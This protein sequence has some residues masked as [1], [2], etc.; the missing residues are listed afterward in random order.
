[1]TATSSFVVPAVGSTV[2][3]TVSDAS[4][5]IPGQMVNVAGAAGTGVAGAFQVQGV[6]GNQLTL[7]NPTPAPAIPPADATQAG[8][9]KQLSGNTTDFVD[10]T[11]TCQNLATAVT[12]TITSVRLR[13]FNAVGNC[14]FEVDQRNAQVALTTPASQTFMQDRW[15][16][17]NSVASMSTALTAGTI[18]LPGTNFAV[19]ARYLRI[20]LATQRTSLVAGDLWTL[21]Q[22]VEGINWRELSFDVT[23]LSLLVRSSIAPLSFGVTL[24]DST[25]VTSLSSL[26]T[27]SAANTWTLIKFPNIPI[28]GSGSFL[29]APG[30]VGYYI[31]ICLYAGSTYIAPAAGIWQAGNF[32]APPGMSN[33]AANAVNSTFDIA[34]V[35]HEPGAQATTLIDKPFS[36]NYDE[37]QRYYTKSYDYG[38]GVGTG[39]AVGC[40]VAFGYIPAAISTDLQ[41]NI[42]FPKPMAK[43][44]TVVSYDWSTGAANSVRD[45]GANANRPVTGN[46]QLGTTGVRS[47]TLSTGI[48]ANSVG[49]FHYTADTGW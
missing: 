38:V 31:Y 14:N 7:L 32:V 2:V 17:Y 30:S 9:L 22:T 37:C 15:K 39:N 13:S 49:L 48:A 3:V 16:T 12:P 6:S 45:L 25:A 27:I 21:T 29:S 11:N 24:Q 40:L 26:A 1:V 5:V 19:T 41:V 42:R 34:F 23:S 47:F 36:Q 43:I 33:F 44:P 10:G 28:P 20:T 4:W 46:N 18:L 35:Q 8:L